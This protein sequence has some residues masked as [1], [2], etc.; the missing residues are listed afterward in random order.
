MSRSAAA[1]VA[2]VILSSSVAAPGASGVR[3]VRQPPIT[4]TVGGLYT[5]DWMSTGST[6]AVTIATGE[7]VTI[8]DSTVT[9]LD[10]GT[11]VET[12]YSVP[13]NVTL[14]HVSAY[15]GNGRFYEAENF[16][17]IT[18]RNC[19]IDRTSGIY[20]ASGAAGSSVV[21][22]RNKQRNVQR[23]SVNPGNFVQLAEIQD[24]TV[25]I[26]WNE[27][28]NE[29]GMSEPEDVIS[30]YK[31][32]H[33]RIHDNY[34]QGGYPLTNTSQSSANG[35]T[36]EV[37]EG[38]PPASFDNSIWNN[39]VVDN[40]GGIG[41][42]GGYDNSAHGNRIVQDGRLP[43]GSRLLA[44]NLGLAVWNIGG[45]P[46]F[47]NNHVWANLV[48][49]VNAAGRRN[50]MWFPD[51]PGDYTLNKRLPGKITRALERAQW[52]AWRAKLASRH[53]RIG[54]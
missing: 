44:A 32:S 7:P 16:K 39:T 23:G 43:T 1:L 29:F 11:L 51:A 45:F 25:D 37:G 33:A 12:P 6:P 18:I 36:V 27:I 54:A 46:D 28:V 26:S 47:A 5:G 19:T 40:V 30:I 9:N 22:T 48:G 35:I 8:V 31:S 49:Y 2:T 17:A 24:A 38:A 52:T 34:L 53:I 42:V 4:I 50:D 14:D 41:I 13:T 20:L 21:I 3:T 10:G 15:G